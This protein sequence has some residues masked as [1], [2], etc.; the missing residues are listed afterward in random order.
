MAI[1]HPWN[2]EEFGILLENPQLTNEELSRQLATRSVGAINVV[3]S[4]IHNFHEGG[5]LSGLSKLMI[6]R[7]QQGFWVCPHCHETH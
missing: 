6:Y 3:R 1:I 2:S 7:L 4:F 5:D